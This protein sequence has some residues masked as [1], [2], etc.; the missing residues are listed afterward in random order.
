MQAD[1]SRGDRFRLVPSQARRSAGD[2]SAPESPLVVFFPT[3][4]PTDVGFLLQGPYRTATEPQ[5]PNGWSLEPASCRGGGRAAS[6]TFC[7][8]WRRA[9]ML[10]A[11]TREIFRRLARATVRTPQIRSSFTMHRAQLCTCGQ[12]AA[13]VVARPARPFST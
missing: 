9:E 12:C 5:R 3:V 6:R 7:D 1:R 13:L 10:S 11:R 4:L 2:T 8:G